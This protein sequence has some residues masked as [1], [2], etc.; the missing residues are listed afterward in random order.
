MKST[1]GGASTDKLPDY[2]SSFRGQQSSSFG[3][4][5]SVKTLM[6]SKDECLQSRAVGEATVKFG[7]GCNLDEHIRFGQCLDGKCLNRG[8][9]EKSAHQIAHTRRTRKKNHTKTKGSTKI[10]LVKDTPLHFACQYN[11]LQVIKYLCEGNEDLN[12]T[13][14]QVCILKLYWI[15]VYR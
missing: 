15:E 12:A 6:D 7:Y 4:N 10:K 3:M 1:S 8:Y 5:T 13:N 2:Y 9:W 11:K 14:G